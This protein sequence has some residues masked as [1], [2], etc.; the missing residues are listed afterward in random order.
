[1]LNSI[2]FVNE[3]PLKVAQVAVQYFGQF[4]GI[5]HGTSMRFCYSYQTVTSLEQVGT[6]NDVTLR[7]KKI[8]SC[9]P[10]R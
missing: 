8:Y 1:M 7:E 10:V 3:I 2:S 4:R 6:G 5:L 9:S